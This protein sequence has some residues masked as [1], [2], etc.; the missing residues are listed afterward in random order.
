M[1][2]IR[3]ITLIGLSTLL[4]IAASSQSNSAPAIR[5]SLYAPPQKDSP[6]RIT[7]FQNGQSEIS[8]VLSNTSDK[9]VAA[10]IIGHADIVPRGCSTVPSID[11]HDLLKNSSAAGLRVSIPP[12]GRG[13]AG[14]AGIVT[15][16]RGASPRY[17]HW[18]RIFINI[19]KSASAGYMQ[20]QFGV[21]G[22]LFEDGSAWPTQIAFLSASDFSTEKKP[23]AAQVTA[24]STVSHPNPF[25][26]QLVEADAGKC[27]DVANVANALQSVKEIVFGPE[28][29]PNSDLDDAA[30]AIP[31]LRFSCSLEGQKAVCRLPLGHRVATSQ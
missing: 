6:V 17:P 8:F 5:F 16:G 1:H 31:H 12:H 7:G 20:L 3:T 9:A 11:P 29:P 26:P 4:A 10:V 28:T 27:T 25:D 2:C 15:I 24:M 22:V 23:S 21:T 14:R 30:N 19:A 18:P 13:S